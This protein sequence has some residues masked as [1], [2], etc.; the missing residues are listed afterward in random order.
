MIFLQGRTPAGVIDDDINEDACAERV[1]GKRKF[2]KLVNAGGAFIEFDQGGINGGQIQCGI[3]TAETSK[4]RVSRGCRM[5]RKQMQ[6]P[7][8]EG[9]DDVRQLFYQVAECPRGRNGGKIFYV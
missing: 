1:R 9:L 7:A 6:N 8:A 3:R 2:A 5:D 4:T